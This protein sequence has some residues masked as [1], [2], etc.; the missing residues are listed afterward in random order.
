MQKGLF[1]LAK[2]AA[3]AVVLS[4]VG[5]GCAADQGDLN[6]VQPGYVKKADLLGKSWYYRRTV[7]DA[8]EGLG[9][10]ATP[11]T[12]DLFTIE[13]VRFEIQEDYLIAFRDYEYIPGSEEAEYDGAE[14]YQGTP[15]V[16]FPI[17]SHFD[18][19]REYNSGTD[20]QTNVISENS[21]DRV[22]Y[23]REFIRVAWHT[24]Q[25]SDSDYYI[26]PV[27]LI[28]G[29]GDG[30]HFYFH[31]DDAANPWR[32]RVNPDRGYVDFVADHFIMPDIE[33]CYY[34]YDLYNCGSGEIKVRHAFT[35][36]DEEANAKYEALYY[37]DSVPVLDANGNEIKDATTGEV[38]RESVF[39][40]F[41]FYRLERLTYDDHR[42]LTESGRLYRILRFDIWENSYD[43][44]G[45]VLPYAQR[46]PKAITYYLNWDFPADLLDSAAEVGA[47]WNMAFR[48]AVA[49]MQGKPVASIPD[50][51]VLKPNTCTMENVKS[52]LA[53]NKSVRKQAES[54]VGSDVD[55]MTLETLD[56]FCAAAEYY[57]QDQKSRF[58]WQQVGDPRF[59]MLVWINE[60][61]PSGFSGYGPMLADPTNG[62]I[63]V[64]TANI[65]GWTID[66]AATRALE[67]IDYMNGDLTLEDLLAGRNVPG[68]A[69][70]P[71]Y[72]PAAHTQDLE[73]VTEMAA[74]TASPEH[75]ASLEGRFQA[76]GDTKEEMLV[77]LDN[78]AHF[79]ERLARI[80]GTNLEFEYLTR[81]ED[82]M[83]ATRGE[84]MPGMPVTDD[85]KKQASLIRRF[86]EE[87]TRSERTARF[88]QERTF[89]K[90]GADL[91]DALVGLARELKDMPR[92][93][94][95]QELVKRIFKAVS[96]HELGHNVGLRHN[97]EASY[98]ALN[99][100]KKFWEIETAGLSTQDKLNAKQPELMYSSIMDYHGKINAD[101]AG[102]GMYDRAAIKFGYGQVLETF[103]NANVD[104]GK[105]MKAWRFSNNYKNLPGHVGSVDKMYD[106][107]HMTW[108][109][110]KDENR[111]QTAV[112]SLNAD[113]VPYL[114][115]SD[116]YANMTPTCKR[117]DF[118]ADPREQ[119]A[120]NYVRYKNYFIFTNYLRN[121][122]LMDFGSVMYRGYSVFSDIVMT[123]QYMYLYRS[124][125]KN[126]LSTDYGKD[127]AAAVANGFNLMTE[128]IA[129]PTPG[130][131]YKCTD[132]ATSNK[133]Y[134][135]GGYIYYD[136]LVDV[137]R[138]EGID[139]EDCDMDANIQLGLGD[140]QPL[141]LGFS[142]DFVAWTFTYLGTYWDKEAALTL[143]ANPTA[144]F[145]RVNGQEDLR[146]F[147]VSP[148]RVYD[149]EML[150]LMNSLIRYNRKELGSR[151]D[152][153]STNRLMPRAL[154][155]ASQPLVDL[156]T[157]APPASQSLPVVVP[158]L[159]RNLQRTAVLY[160]TALLT[161]PLDDSLDFAK[162]TR[163]WLKGGFDDLPAFNSL[164]AGDRAECTLPDVG[165]TFRAIKVAD[166]F[167]ISFD[168]VRECADQVTA[169]GAAGTALAAAVAAVTAAEAANANDPALPALR[170]AETDARFELE[171]AQFDLASTQQMLQWTRAVHAVFEHGA[172]L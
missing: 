58:E 112:T 15:V 4:T 127:M 45:N 87:T 135:P 104:G 21:S 153:V 145:F 76:L 137:N 33:T 44:A 129:M 9:P 167:N 113:L 52:F 154:V 96:L 25:L 55:D 161:S 88:L 134:Y 80:E 61:V 64:A 114:F 164:P 117:F 144:R 47:E 24:T 22:W 128:V 102:L 40:R 171:N 142:E 1:G 81:A 3:L 2:L 143:F 72:D 147:S 91:D 86:R 82:L 78:S 165:T 95:R 107:G 70:D 168:M 118:G 158:S 54:V 65:M 14:D 41:G 115:C 57:S 74:K 7:V 8:P 172:E 151:F 159:A 18:I 140:A 108:D 27:D 11:G 30:G 169:Y 79:D 146:A 124:L 13:R 66:N 106:R 93:Q 62:R 111:T 148:F 97:F 155:D 23:E 16:A 138:G 37:P 123:Y 6:L 85:L 110:T 152:D 90:F 122:L 48:E 105:A 53:A 94:R 59:N 101:F 50:M 31:E 39:D 150:G 166:N 89:C 60:I 131:Y 120:A 141:F 130:T 103:T 69:S 157:P 92:A 99:F 162:H 83:L 77:P 51:F 17:T 126:F 67:Y 75:M 19:K 43:A 34:E 49:A 29:N 116:E 36:V 132:L 42:G 10:Y 28:D 84:W 133:V 121:R 136:P 5:V 71:N 38:V 109:W 149:K 156:E 100:P 26:I 35:Q 46:T 170:Q 56:N 139:G 20:E 63:V 160:G 12:G 73:S 32:A 125:D 68:I 163:V 119:M 98:D